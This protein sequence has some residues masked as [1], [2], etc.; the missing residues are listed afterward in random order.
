[1][2]ALLLTLA[3]VTANKFQKYRKRKLS[4]LSNYLL[5]PQAHKGGEKEVRKKRKKRKKRKEGRKEG[6]KKERK[7]LFSSIYWS[8]NVERIV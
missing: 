5:E 1:M 2:N 3:Y 8:H 6:R 4:V 7:V